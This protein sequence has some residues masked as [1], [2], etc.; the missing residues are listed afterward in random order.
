MIINQANLNLLT[1]GFRTNFRQAFAGVTPYWNRV[2]TQVNST[3][4]AEN[5][6]WLGS[7]PRLREWVGDRVIQ[8]IAN[9]DY[10]IRNKDFEAT[11]TVP[12]NAIE[13]DQY[14]LFSPLMGE[15]GDA[16]GRH[17]D[18]ILFGLLKNGFNTPCYDG[19]AFFDTD[20]PV[21]LPGY[22]TTVSNMQAGTGPAW[23]L[24][25]TKR[26][27]KPLIYQKR[28]AYDFIAKIDP[29]QSD[30]VF[31]QK[32]FVYGVDG[33]MNGGFGLW[34]M[35]AG[36]KATLNEDNFKALYEG[37]TLLNGDQGNPL[38]LKPNVLVVGPRLNFTARAMIESQMINATSN[39]LYKIVDIIDVPW[40]D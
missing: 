13:D 9:Y 27:L 16:A 34:Q 20:H 21:G 11:V 29:R 1:T 36:S 37:M 18:E 39:P 5:Y 2:A 12:R 6:S 22:Q 25:D 33:R 17:P 35:A 40:L 32:E 24:M 15:M 38:G 7:F 28:R 8:S 30:H 26:P 23:F 31:T 4:A 3:T 14:G 19:Q 10:T